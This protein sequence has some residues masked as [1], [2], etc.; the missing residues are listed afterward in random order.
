MDRRL[1][2]RNKL[3]DKGERAGCSRYAKAE[4]TKCT[5][6]SA[7]LTLRLRALDCRRKR[8]TPQTTRAV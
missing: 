8:M 3:N 7:V 4:A 1:L 2:S 5:K 6:V